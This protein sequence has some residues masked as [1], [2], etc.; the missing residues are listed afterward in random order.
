MRLR[1]GTSLIVKEIDASAGEIA[2]SLCQIGRLKKLGDELNIHAKR[3][4]LKAQ[5]S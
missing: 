2:A 5:Q 3:E 1:F 4:F